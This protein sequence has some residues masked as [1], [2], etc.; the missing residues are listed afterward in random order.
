MSTKE[1]A[2]QDIISLAKHNNISLDEIKHALQTAPVLA[3][4]PSSSVLSK[5]FAYVG[6]LG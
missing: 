3:S 4:K 2:L 1:D 5:L 6:V